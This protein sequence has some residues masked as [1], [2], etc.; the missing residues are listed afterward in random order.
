M[1]CGAWKDEGVVRRE[2]DC[3]A[4]LAARTRTAK[5]RAPSE[6][7]RRRFVPRRTRRHVHVLRWRVGAPPTRKRNTALGASM[8]QTARGAHN[9]CVSRVATTKKGTTPGE[10]R[11]NPRWSR[12]TRSPPA[13]LPRRARRRALH[14]RRLHGER[15]A[16]LRRLRRA[17]RRACAAR[18]RLG[19]PWRG[20]VMQRHVMSCGTARPRLGGPWRGRGVGT[21]R[22]PD[23]A[24]AEF[25]HTEPAPFRHAAEPPPNG[26]RDARHDTRPRRAI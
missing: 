26:R 4:S 24:C 16:A 10:E 11:D 12:R 5:K 21:P 20:R 2:K 13:G 15:G 25:V 6:R 18:P 19:G 17:P 8:P 23:A 3:A 22:H 14:R 9:G 7:L 1:R